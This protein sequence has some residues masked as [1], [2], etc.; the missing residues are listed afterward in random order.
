MELFSVRSTTEDDWRE[1][2]D[3]RLEMLADTPIAFGEHHAAAIEHSEV[4]WRQ[5][6]AR[7]TSPTTCSFAAI[8]EGG[9]WVATMG[10]VIEGGAP[11]LVGVYV[12]PDYRGRGGPADDLLA[13]VEQWAIARNDRLALR[14]HSE[15]ARARAYYRSHG[16]V[17]TGV[18]VP[19]VLDRSAIELEMVKAL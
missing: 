10:G 4:I 7:G 17:E 16:F 15:N 19:Y 12:S 3:L 1:V 2:R 11:L 14:V 6:G 13:A 8:T 5:R 9:R 18:T